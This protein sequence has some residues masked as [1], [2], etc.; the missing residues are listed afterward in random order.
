MKDYTAD[1]RL[2]HLKTAAFCSQMAMI[3]RAGLPAIEGISLM[4]ADA[5][6]PSEKELLQ[7]VQEELL[8]SSQFCDALRSVGVFPDYMV[9]MV[10]IGEQTGTLDDVMSGLSKHYEREQ[11]I[12]KSIRSALTYPLIMIGIMI[13]VIV[14]L[15]TKVMPVFS[16][17]FKQL[18]HEMTG[19]SKA[20]LTMGTVLS[21][22]AVFFIAAMIV[23]LFLLFYFSKTTSGR[24]QFK[25]LGHHIG[26]VRSI[27]DKIC[28][29]RLASGMYL[30]LRSGLTPD[31]G[32]LLTK[33]LIDN[34]FFQKKISDCESRMSDGASLSEAL[35]SS[36]IFSGLYAR[37]TAIAD[38]SGTM[39]EVLE[40]IAKQYETEADD[41][42]TA[43]IAA[44]EPTL[45]IILSVIVGM[46]LL[47]V[48]IPLMGM[49][50]GL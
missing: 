28:A 50:A 27:S 34:P 31:Q 42:M 46:L 38:R 5:Q 33:E 23:I 3:L 40:Q 11:E 43:W 7:K 48:M 16:Q 41:A 44:L 14:V 24:R 18:G 15:L 25:N 37:M 13:L 8:S 35:T 32:L 39:D 10:T 9:Q 19:F 30:A 1:G 20:A 49:M 6:D 45:V 17:V 29:S 47:S 12:A 4:L 26:F 22:Y 2:S 36:H 21:N